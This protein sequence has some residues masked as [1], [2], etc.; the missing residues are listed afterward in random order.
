MNSGLRI[1]KKVK[2]CS[3]T[4][5]RKAC[6]FPLHF[7]LAFEEL[8]NV[9]SAQI[10]NN[11]MRYDNK[12]TLSLFWTEE[13]CENTITSVLWDHNNVTPWLK[14]VYNW[15]WQWVYLKTLLLQHGLKSVIESDSRCILNCYGI[16]L[17]MCN[18]IWQ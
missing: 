11:K 6:W 7:S 10:S 18:W 4:Y 2:Y 12:C 3:V 5:R 16:V 13:L 14:R 8:F 1:I 17:E 15:V 9:T